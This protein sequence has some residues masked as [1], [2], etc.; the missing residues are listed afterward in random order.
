MNIKELLE[1][2]KSQLSEVTG[3]KAM[4]IAEVFKNE[5]GWHVFLEM[6]ELSR[7]PSATDIL[8]E[9][10]VILD[11]EG[12]LLSFERKRT[13]LRCQAVEREEKVKV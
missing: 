10:E 4:T 12:N 7:I 3:L 8:G 6:L 2:A 9:Y 5:R 13:R 1:Q 11:N